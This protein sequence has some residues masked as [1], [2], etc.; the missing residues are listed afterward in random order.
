[1]Y[2]K[3]MEQ[4][5]G[6]IFAIITTLVVVCVGTKSF[7]PPY[8]YDQVKAGLEKAN[9]VSVKVGDYLKSGKTTAERWVSYLQQAMKTGSFGRSYTCI[10]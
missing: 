4:S 8:T 1:M 2:I 7:V 10:L 9:A 6:V 3:V 5:C